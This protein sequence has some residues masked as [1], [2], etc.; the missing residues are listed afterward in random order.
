MWWE[1]FTGRKSLDHP[2]VMWVMETKWVWQYIMER[3][4][5]NRGV[6]PLVL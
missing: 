4:D 1:Y 3:Y 5:E 6:P 2:L